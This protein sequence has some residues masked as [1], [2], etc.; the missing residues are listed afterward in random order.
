M[1]CWRLRWRRRRPC[2]A[3]PATPH[4]QLP[5]THRYPPLQLHSFNHWPP[6]TTVPPPAAHRRKVLLDRLLADQLGDAPLRLGVERVGGRELVLE[7]LR[8]GGGELRAAQLLELVLAVWEGG[9]VL[10]LG[11]IVSARGRGGAP[12]FTP[13]THAHPPACPPHTPTHLHLGDVVVADRLGE[14]RVAHRQ[15]GELLRL[16]LER[17]DERD[18]R[19]GGAVGVELDGGVG[20]RPLLLL[21]LLAL[22]LL[23]RAASAGA[24]AGGGRGQQHDHRAVGDAGRGQRRAGRERRVVVDQVLARGGHAAVGLEDRLERVDRLGGVDLLL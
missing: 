23:L 4:H 16:R 7:A 20:P 17:L 2:A 6:T 3:P 19:L 21:L 11:R 10:G 9:E 1:T 18:G 15:G 12:P 24:S 22:P 8:L 5:A 13:P 14:R